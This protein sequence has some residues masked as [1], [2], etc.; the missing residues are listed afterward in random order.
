MK[1]SR[2]QVVK[3]IVNHFVG[4]ENY[5]DAIGVI[6]DIDPQAANQYEVSFSTGYIHWFNKDEII[7]ATEDEITRAFVAEVLFNR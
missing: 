7:Y 6:T 3:V 1:Y 2:F 5:C 4:Q